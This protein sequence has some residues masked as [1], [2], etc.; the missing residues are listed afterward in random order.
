[1]VDH[2]SGGRVEFGVGRSSPYEQMGL[3]IDPRDTRDI[4][5]ESIKIVP[6]IWQTEGNFSWDGKFFNIPE[7]EVLPKPLQRPHPPMWMACTQPA[8]YEIAAKHGIGVLSF[9]SGAPSATSGS[10]RMRE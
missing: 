5:E 2:V 3:G 1:M 7:R 4:M 8:S 9:G 10:L 6:K